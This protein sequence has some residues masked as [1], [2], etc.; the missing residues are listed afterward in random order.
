MICVGLSRREAL[1]DRLNHSWPKVAIQALAC[2]ILTNVMPQY[3]PRLGGFFQYIRPNSITKASLLTRNKAPKCDRRE[4]NDCATSPSH[5]CCW[6]RKH[7]AHLAA[8][9]SFRVMKTAGPTNRVRDV[10]SEIDDRES[11]RVRIPRYVTCT[12][13]GRAHSPSKDARR[14]SP[15]STKMV[16]SSRRCPPRP[17][18]SFACR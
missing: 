2:L 13:A 10:V 12:G 11:R 3:Q 18:I 17:T 16:D 6:G 14:M 1:I 5:A 8:L 4:E 15:S 7:H 9:T